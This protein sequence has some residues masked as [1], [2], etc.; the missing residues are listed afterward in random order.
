[1]G[2]TI[3]AYYAVSAWSQVL[4]WPAKQVPHYKYGWKVTLFPFEAKS[5][6]KRSTDGFL[7][8]L[9][10]QVSIGLFVALLIGLFTLR[11]I[12]LRYIRPQNYRIAQEKKFREAD[13]AREA[14]GLDSEGDVKEGFEPEEDDK[15]STTVK[16]TS[17]D[18]Q[19]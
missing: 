11:I 9:Y 12:D 15:R 2:T 8:S 14:E 18:P 6:S 19:V 1:M 17:V 10:S 13:E 5:E 3:A 16:V 4:I 7:P